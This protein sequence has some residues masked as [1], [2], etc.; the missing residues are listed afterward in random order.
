MNIRMWGILGGHLKVWLPEMNKEKGRWLD[1]AE[2]EMYSLLSKELIGAN[3]IISAAYS[4]P[5]SH[6]LLCIRSLDHW[7]G[8]QV[9]ALGV[10]MR[11]SS[12]QGHVYGSLLGDS[13]KTFWPLIRRRYSGETLSSAPT[14]AL[15]FPCGAREWMLKEAVTILEPWGKGQRYS[16]VANTKP[17]I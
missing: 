4:R 17:Q 13:G 6:M 2:M 12:G 14:S 7:K 9:L 11:Y 8:G 15:I 10:S 16:R 5:I 1:R 3:K